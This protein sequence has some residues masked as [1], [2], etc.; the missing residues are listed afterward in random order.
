MKIADSV[1][2]MVICLGD[3]DPVSCNKCLQHGSTVC[4]TGFLPLCFVATL[5]IRSGFAVSSIF[6][7]ILLL[8]VRYHSHVA[9]YSVP[10]ITDC[11]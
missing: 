3:G 8:L 1:E 4:E 9:K 2:L 7:S 5:L 11:I 6:Y 10:C